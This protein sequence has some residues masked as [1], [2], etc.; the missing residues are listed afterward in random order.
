MNILFALII[1]QASFYK[2]Q[3]CQPSFT[4]N[5]NHESF[6]YDFNPFLT[7]EKKP[8]I[9]IYIIFDNQSIVS[10]A[11]ARTVWSTK[12]KL[13]TIANYTQYKRNIIAMK[14]DKKRINGKENWK[15]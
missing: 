9:C 13:K 1:N 3:K 15:S 2:S 10:A 11:L 7:Y 5:V 14:L 12:K 4:N 8:C 6:P